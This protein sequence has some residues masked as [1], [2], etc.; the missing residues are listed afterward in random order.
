M[1][2]HRLCQHPSWSSARLLCGSG[3]EGDAADDGASDPGRQDSHSHRN[4]VEERSGFRSTKLAAAS[5]LIIS[6]EEGF[7][8]LGFSPVGVGRVREMLDSRVSISQ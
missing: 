5:S 8:S 3:G 6:G 4:D 7:P 1:A 2:Q